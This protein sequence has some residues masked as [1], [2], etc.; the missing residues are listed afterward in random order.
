MTVEASVI[1]VAATDRLLLLRHISAKPHTEMII[2]Y[3]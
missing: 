1:P 2:F 3:N